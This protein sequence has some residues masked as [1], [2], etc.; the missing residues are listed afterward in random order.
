MSQLFSALII[1]DHPLTS[2]AYKSAFERLSSIDDDFKFNIAIDNN[3][4]DAIKTIVDSS[5]GDKIDLFFLD[6]NLPPSQDG[7]YLS[8]EDL[9]IKIRELLPDAKIIVSTTFYDNYRI[10]SIIKSIDPDGFLIK[11][12]FDLQELVE[13]I[14]KVLKKPPYYSNTVLKSLRKQFSGDI[15][16]DSLD[17]QLL[18]ELSIGTKMKELPKILP[19]SMAGIEKRKRQLKEIFDIAKKE[20]RDLILIAKEKGFI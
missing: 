19:M 12:D 8:G 18:H 10:H 20:D 3:C 9:G 7:K 16:I 17:R 6:I 15:A 4:S 11:N 1:E 13:A 14:K 5:K 2:S